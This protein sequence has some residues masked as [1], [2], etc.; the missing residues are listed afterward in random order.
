MRRRGSRRSGVRRS[1]SIHRSYP[2]PGRV[3]TIDN[4]KFLANLPS[5][6][7]DQFLGDDSNGRCCECATPRG[8]AMSDP[9]ST[10]EKTIDIFVLQPP[11][12]CVDA[13]N[14]D[15]CRDYL[16]GLKTYYQF[17]GITQVQDIQDFIKQIGEQVA[18]SG[19]KIKKLVIGSHGIGGKG[20][21]FRIGNNVIDQSSFPEIDALRRAAPFF[22]KNADVFIMACRTGQNE[23]LLKR[24]SKALG[25]VKVHGYTD[26]I[27]TD[28][29]TV[30]I[31]GDG[32][33]N[34]CTESECTKTD[35]RFPDRKESPMLK[36]IHLRTHG[37][38]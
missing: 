7:D 33:E 10:P 37:R 2:Q 8:K 24:V 1:R 25:G 11:D 38:F 29:I 31:E 16:S 17:N 27:E 35:P 4:G 23:T 12:K 6:S 9:T 20:A 36:E 34:V 19:A 26:G 21:Y 32:K 15:D 22:A 3:M 5:G 18:K 28:G 13:H 30:D 14:P